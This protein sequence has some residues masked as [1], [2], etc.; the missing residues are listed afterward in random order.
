M[1]TTSGIELRPYQKTAVARS[2]AAFAS[3]VRRQVVSLPVG[4]GKTVIF[5]ALLDALPPPTP[6]ATKTLVLAHRVELL[7]QAR[8]RIAD[9]HPTLRVEIEQGEANASRDADVVV[10]SVPTLGRASQAAQLRL[11]YFDPAE[12]KLIIIDEAHHATAPTYTRILDHFGL[13]KDSDEGLAV[14]GPPPTAPTLLWGCSATVRRHDG[15][16]LGAVFD[17]ITYHRSMLE[18][19][20]EGWLA[21]LK[22]FT[23]KTTTDLSA[24]KSWGGDFALSHLA[25]HVNRPDRNAI[26]LE[27]WL[28]LAAAPPAGLTLSSTLVFAVDVQ[29]ILDLQAAFAAEGIDARYV[30]GM[31]PPAERAALVDAF[32]A[33]EFPVLINC[34]VFTEGTDIPIIDCVVLARPTKSQG[35]FQ[36]MLGRGLRTAPGKTAC[37]VL[38]VVDSFANKAKSRG[39]VTLPSLLG[40]A[41]D[42]ALVNQDLAQLARDLAPLDDL[43]LGPSVREAASMDEL[44]LVR[45]LELARVDPFDPRLTP[46]TAHSEPGHARSADV[47][48]QIIFEVSQNAWAKTGARTFE[49]SLGTPAMGSLHIHHELDPAPGLYTVSQTYR[50]PDTYI[51]KTRDLPLTASSLEDALR[52]ADTYLRAQYPGMFSV[53]KRNAPWRNGPASDAQKKYLVRLGFL[54]A[55]SQA[56]LDCLSKGQAQLVISRIK[57]YHADAKSF[58]LSPALPGLA[59]TK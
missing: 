38:D 13:A 58:G 41:P 57:Q 7:Q 6:K 53:F 24:V 23:V 5:A 43:P 31:T 55:R 34:G 44:R 45:E 51:T 9:A 52:G 42:F 36:Q 17:A 4:S 30:H 11:K 26:L 10:G 15:L 22:V 47:D 32:R 33:K 27:N 21:P 16:G 54:K 46:A 18:M 25:A 49:L 48:S 2:L 50:V 28:A 1:T 40:L 56:E 37:I 39:L 59:A 12:F 20:D 29:H 8:D 35:L 19:M 14:P 3:G